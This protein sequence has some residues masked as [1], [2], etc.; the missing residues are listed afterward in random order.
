[1][2]TDIVMMPGKDYQAICDAVRAKTGGTELL[3][4]GDIPAQIEGISGGGEKILYMDAELLNAG[5]AYPADAD[6]YTTAVI[7]A[8]AYVSLDVFENLPNVTK[9]IVEGDCEFETYSDKYDMWTVYRTALTYSGQITEFTLNTSGDLARYYA[10]QTYTL[11]KVNV[12]CDEMFDSAFSYCYGLIEAVVRANFLAGS[13]FNYCQ[14]L[15]KAEFDFPATAIP[16]Y[17]FGNCKRL[18]AF[19]I[20][21]TVTEIG[22]Y[23]FQY[24]ERLTGILLPNGLTTLGNY[25]FYYCKSLTEIVIPGGV[26][27]IGNYAFY[28]CDNLREVTIHEGVA[29]IGSNAF[30]YCNNLSVITIPASVTSIGSASSSYAPTIPKTAVIRGYA[31]S[32]AETYASENGYTFEVIE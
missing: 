3:K 14:S 16:S 21:E 15:K 31:G 10:Y 26:G 19:N 1:M 27:S 18:E 20:P 28:H 30:S 29:S 11:R 5:G 23:A 13:A 4:S 22:T 12:S 9:A 8:G 24:C 25:A 6:D 17:T 2:I 32:Y 7:P